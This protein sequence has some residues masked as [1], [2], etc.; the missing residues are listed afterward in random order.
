MLVSMWRGPLVSI[1]NYS[2]TVQP[3]HIAIHYITNLPI[4][5]SQTVHLD[6]IRVLVQSYEI[7]SVIKFFYIESI[8]VLWSLLFL[9]VLKI[10]AKFCYLLV[11]QIAI[12]SDLESTPAYHYNKTMS[13]KDSNIGRLHCTNDRVHYK[14]KTNIILF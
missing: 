12:N 4:Y 13:P 9:P 14:Y 2:H 6:V 8:T 5:I 11:T 1:K 3:P 10:I 7:N